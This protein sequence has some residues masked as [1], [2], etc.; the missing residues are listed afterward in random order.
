MT[1]FTEAI[2]TFTLATGQSTDHYNVKQIGLYTGLQLEELAEKLTAF[3]L[4]YIADQ[5]DALSSDF[6]QGK[7]ASQIAQADRAEVLDADLDLAWVSVGAAHS[8]GANVS[9]AMAE[10]AR[11][12]LA[13][14]VSCDPCGGVGSIDGQIDTPFCPTC[15]GAGKV[16]LKDENGKVKKPA[17]WTAPNLMPHII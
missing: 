8:T 4:T 1:Q 15:R 13:K 7:L 10:I 3:G 2:A 6:K 16:A 14:L 9:G 17:G 5:L 11:S 12:N